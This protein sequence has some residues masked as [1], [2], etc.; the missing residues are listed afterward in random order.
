MN[1]PALQELDQAYGLLRS[2]LLRVLQAHGLDPRSGASIGTK[3]GLNRQLAWQV[4]TIACEPSASAGLAVIPGARGLG[5]FVDASSSSTG[6]GASAEVAGDLVALRQS[7]ERLEQ[8]IAKHAGDRPTLALLAATWDSNEVESRTED[9]RRDAHRAQCALL[10]ARVDTQIRGIIFGRSQQ[11]RNDRV[12]MASYQC[13]RGITRI[14][15]GHRS[16]LFYL[17]LPTNDDGSPDMDAAEMKSFLSEK[18]RLEPDLS[19]GSGNE[20]EYL[21]DRHRGWVVLRSGHIGHA[22]THNLAFTGL[23]AYENP[24]FIEDRNHLNQIAF[25]CQIPTENLLIDCLMDRSL[26]ESSE[27]VRSLTMQCF[28]AS[29]GHPMQPVS[30]EDPAFLYDITDIE[31]LGPEL[32][33]A[34]PAFAR[35]GDLVQRAALRVGSSLDRLVGVRCRARYVI[36]PMSVV[37]TRQLPNRPLA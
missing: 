27:F 10:G 25:V 36:A 6:V 30:R 4:S 17:E 24:R 11:G 22:A 19:T 2:G 28:D 18:F 21:V 15:A 13:L 9:L 32:L 14:R 26:A 16:R 33:S 12:A 37:V 8:T 23:P 7:I 1:D 20:V 29:T 31:P 5:L 3:L 34:D 35:T